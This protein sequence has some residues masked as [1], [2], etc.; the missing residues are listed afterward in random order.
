M[1]TVPKSLIQSVAKKGKVP[2]NNF[3]QHPL[4]R[5]WGGHLPAS[6]L[7][8]YSALVFRVDRWSDRESL[9]KKH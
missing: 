7:S 3:S 1:N 8:R 6:P 2:E 9:N 4:K 5:N